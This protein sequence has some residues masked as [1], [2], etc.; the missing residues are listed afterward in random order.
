LNQN[1]PRGK[2]MKYLTH[3]EIKPRSLNPFA[4]LQRTT[5]LALLLMASS[6]SQSL[7][8]LQENFLSLRYGGFLHFNMGTFT[9][10]E[11]AS[12]GQNPNRFNPTSLN[13]GQWADAAVTAGMKYMTLT[14]KHHDGF[15]LWNSAYTTYDVGSSSWKG[16]KG[17]VVREFVDSLRSR[18]IKISFYYSIWD[19]TNGSDTTFIKNQLT[20]LLTKYGPIEAIWFDGWG[21]KVG[22]TEVPYETIRKHIKSM[23]PNCLILENNHNKNLNNTEMVIFERNLDGLPPSNNTVPTEVCDNIRNDGNWFYN[24]A[25]NCSLKLISAL[26]SS[27]KGINAVRGN[28]LLDL[29]PDTA[30]RIPECQVSHLALLATYNPS[31][32]S[33]LVNQDKA[34]YSGSWSKQGARGFGDFGDDVQYTSTPGDS[35]VISFSGVGIDFITERHRD[36]G[37]F[38]MYLDGV[39][40]ERVSCSAEYTKRLEQTVVFS[41]ANLPMGNHRLKGVFASGSGTYGVIDAFKISRGTPTSIKSQRSHLLPDLE[42]IKFSRGERIELP[43]IG[44][45]QIYAI[46]GKQK[47]LLQSGQSRTFIVPNLPAGIYLIRFKGISGSDMSQRFVLW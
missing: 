13:C 21:W 7:G 43:T 30:G 25:G 39:F 47:A 18:N 15:G 34:T 44:T 8:T 35:F 32:D 9:G 36:H 3:L 24:P 31:L 27:L 41:V 37:A 12:P 2:S 26:Y 4:I 17:D 19:K 46:S 22:Y 11:W 20:E 28:F 23:Q 38:D 6:F 1:N 40:V 33:G 16:G 10:E 5:L 14:T 42:G 45:W 29:T